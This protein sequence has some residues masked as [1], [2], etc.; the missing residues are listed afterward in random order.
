MNFIKSL[1]SHSD[2]SGSRSTILKPLNWL[3]TILLGFAITSYHLRLPKCFTY[4]LVGIFILTILIFF[5]TYLYCLFNDRDALRSETFSLRKMEIEKGFF[6]DSDS[7]IIER[8]SIE[9]K[10]EYLLNSRD[11]EE[12]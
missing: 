4:I 2:A 5:F 10:K 6:G 9:S 3:L 1:L 11:S 12:V 8:N 7:G